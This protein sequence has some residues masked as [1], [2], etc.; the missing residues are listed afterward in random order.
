MDIQQN[1]IRQEVLQ[2]VCLACKVQ[3]VGA[4]SQPFS[5]SFTS[6]W[7]ALVSDFGAGQNFYDRS[8]GPNESKVLER[9][10]EMQKQTKGLISRP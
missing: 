9:L 7:V 8:A 6:G 4:R 10:N 1:E 2:S 5:V 3:A